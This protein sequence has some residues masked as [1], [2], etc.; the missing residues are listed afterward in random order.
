MEQAFGIA[1]WTAGCAHLARADPVMAG[2]VAAYAGER[3]QPHGDVFATL[4]RAITGQ[5]ISVPAAERIWQRLLGLLGEP[6]TGAVVA[7]GEAALAGCGL[8][9]RKAACLTAIAAA[10]EA[11]AALPASREALLAL[12]G[13][14]PWTADMVAIFAL[15]EPDILPLADIGLQRAIAGHYG[16]DREALDRRRM[17]ELALSWRPWRT[18]AVWYLWRDLDPVPVAY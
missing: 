3:L 2:L 5:Q 10:V 6:G 11:G 18:I 7:A 13:V 16:I 4:A 9:R 14:G 17:E 12:P 8:T 15:G 1:E